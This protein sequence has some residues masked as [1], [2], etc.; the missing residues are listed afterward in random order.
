MAAHPSPLPRRF[1]LTP[2]AIRQFRMHTSEGVDVYLPAA[3]KRV[4]EKSTGIHFSEYPASPP[5]SSDG[6]QN[7]SS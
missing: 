3:V 7:V 2:T 1:L 6:P 5:V 4:I